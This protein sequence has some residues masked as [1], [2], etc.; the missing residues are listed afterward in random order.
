M[1]ISRRSALKAMAAATATAAATL[2]TRTAKAA[3]VVA[4]PDAVGLLSDATRCI[5]CKTCMV[6]CNKAN[7]LPPDTGGTMPW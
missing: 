2:R 7:N 1:G 6:A 4:R 3:V 5:G